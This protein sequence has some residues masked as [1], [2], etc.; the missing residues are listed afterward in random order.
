M[1]VD[2]F[3]CYLMQKSAFSHNFDLNGFDSRGTVCNSKLLPEFKFLLPYNKV[4]LN[5][6]GFNEI[7][8]DF[9]AY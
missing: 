4:C 3:I 8:M 7:S 1:I 6:C 2:D 5:K 9:D